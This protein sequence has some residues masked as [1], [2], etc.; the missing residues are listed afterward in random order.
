ML[1]WHHVPLGVDFRGGTD[2]YVNFSTPPNVD[3]IRDDLNR[4]GLRDARIQSAGGNEVLI[5]LAQTTNESNLT[6]GKQRIIDAMERTSPATQDPAN[7][8]RKDFN[9]SSTAT[10]ADALFKRDPLGNGGDPKAY[11]NVARV[12]VKYRDDKQHGILNS[13][14]ELAQNGID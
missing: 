12:I 6:A 7:Q 1:F 5:S 4:V 3:K 14:D 13:F 2:A 10:I 11:G 9:N 8:G